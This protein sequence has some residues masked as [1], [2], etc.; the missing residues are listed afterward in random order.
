M[1]GGRK[2]QNCNKTL[3][4][5]DNCH[6]IPG[7]SIRPY[8]TF[9]GLLLIGA[10]VC[11]QPSAADPAAAFSLSASDADDDG[12]D[13]DE[14]KKQSSAGAPK[15]RVSVKLDN[16]QPAGGDARTV[17]L[18]ETEM[19]TIEHV[20]VSGTFDVTPV[21]YPALPEVEGPRRPLAPGRTWA[22]RQAVT[23]SQLRHERVLVQF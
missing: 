3:A 19:P 10:F 13:R 23:L 18:L 7:M 17:A 15:K 14:D 2:L 21:E 4:P 11:V 20:L 1:F 9:A 22:A 16:A 5:A 6:L 8:T 12:D